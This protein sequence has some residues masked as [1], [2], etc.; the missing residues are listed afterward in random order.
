M[1]EKMLTATQNINTNEKNQRKKQQ[2]R[3]LS[4]SFAA[5]VCVYWY[6]GLSLVSYLENIRVRY[7]VM[8]YIFQI[9]FVWQENDFGFSSDFEKLVL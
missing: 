8:K 4:R 3:P 7:V 5:A 9:M 6:T 2:K 1:T